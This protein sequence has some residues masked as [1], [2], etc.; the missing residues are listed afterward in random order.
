M[1][2]V[3]Q[4]SENLTFDGVRIMPDPGSGRTTAAWADGIQVSGCK[5]KVLIKD[6]EFSGTHDDPINVH[7][8]HLRVVER[9]PDNQIKV[10]FMHEQTFGFLAFNPGDEVDFV[11]QK[12]L[13]TYG[14]NRVKDARMISPTDILLTLEKPVTAEFQADDALENVTWTPELEI[15][16]CKVSRIPT[17]GFLVT[18][19]RPVLIEDNEFNGTHMSAILI[20]GDASGWYESGCVRDMTIRGNRF[21]RCNS[22]VI[23]VNP[24]NTEP[25]PSVHQNIRILNNEF[26]LRGKTLVHARSTTGLKV[27]DNIVHG[28]I[29]RERAVVT[30]ECVDVVMDRNTEVAVE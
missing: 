28:A 6:C 2:M 9:L 26:F 15:R 16:G 17:R 5:G 1:G 4:F 30:D 25:N 23:H 24:R 8:T 22:P 3:N 27:V 10:R 21:V 7:G 14:T 18:T 20:E 11:R 19:R 12:T 29:D 13:A